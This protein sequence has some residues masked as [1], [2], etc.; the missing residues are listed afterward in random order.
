LRPIIVGMLS[1]RIRYSESIDRIQQA[2][3]PREVSAFLGVTATIQRKGG[4]PPAAPANGP[5]V[6]HWSSC[7]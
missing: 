4:V 7:A 1:L 2:S 6:L 3:P 5:K